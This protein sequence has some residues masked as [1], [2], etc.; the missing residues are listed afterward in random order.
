MHMG[1]YTKESKELQDVMH[2]GKMILETQ[3]W[4]YH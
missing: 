2:K 3:K 4:S 1:M